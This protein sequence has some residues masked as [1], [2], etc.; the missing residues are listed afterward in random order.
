MTASHA[1]RREAIPIQLLLE[2]SLGVRPP[3][4]H[5]ID[6]LQ[7]IAAIRKGYSK[8][9]RQ[10]RRTQRVAI[11]VLNECVND[12]ELMMTVHHQPTDG[13]K[14][15]LFTKALNTEKF[16]NALLMIDLRPMNEGPACELEN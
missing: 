13:M 16:A 5:H 15:D 11:G 14:A 4:D 3:I 8:K 12:P 2:E 6:N 9:L 1:M 7:A 10:L